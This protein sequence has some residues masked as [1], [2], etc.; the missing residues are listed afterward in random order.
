MQQICLLSC[1]LSIDTSLNIAYGGLLSLGILEAVNSKENFNSDV[2]M[3]NIW[4]NGYV[5]LYL[6]HYG[7]HKT[8]IALLCQ[9]FLKPVHPESSTCGLFWGGPRLSFFF[10][11][12]P[13][14]MSWSTHIFMWGN[15]FLE[16]IF[17]NKI[18]GNLLL[19]GLLFSFSVKSSFYKKF[20]SDTIAHKKDF[21]TAEYIMWST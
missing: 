1:Y 10:F 2:F 16:N 3:L 5:R 13:T 17:L 18:V 6:S 9:S 11:F 15:L 21:L 4:R 7:F 8:S 20:I 12:Y 19:I 14:F